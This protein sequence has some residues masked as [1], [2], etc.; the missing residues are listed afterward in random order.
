MEFANKVVLITGAA[1]GIGKATVNKFAQAG[2]KV[3][4]VDLNEAA[5]E[6]TANELGLEKGQ[7]ILIPAD[8]SKEEDVINYVQKQK[9]N[10]AALMFSSTMRA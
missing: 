1:G 3:A 5:L 9:K 10:L 2:A 8:V 7:Y 6:Q 4:L